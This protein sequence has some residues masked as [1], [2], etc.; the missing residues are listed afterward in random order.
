M[1][2]KK[3]KQL[4]SLAEKDFE[5]SRNEIY[6]PA[7]D[8]V[9]YTA[10]VSA[11]RALYHYLHCL[12]LFYKSKNRETYEEP[13]TLEELIDYCSNNDDSIRDLDFNLLYCKCMGMISDEEEE[14]FF[15]N[16]VFKLKYCYELAEGAR[17][18]LLTKTGPLV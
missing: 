2:E 1:D 10:C 3:M 15:C 14:P 9:R 4:F 6:K 5:K 17:E 7:E 8:M 11:R 12:Y 13:E 18:S 16:D